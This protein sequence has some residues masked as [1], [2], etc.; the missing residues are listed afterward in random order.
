MLKFQAGELATRSKLAAAIVLC[1]VG[2]VSRPALAQNCTVRCGSRQIQFIPGQRVRLQM[3]NHTSSLVQIEQL[4]ETDPVP[5][6]PSQEL[7]VNSYFGTEPNT[8]VVFWDET[9]LPVKAVLFRPETNILRIEIFPG[10]RPPGDRSVYIEND[11]H[12]KLF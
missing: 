11:G 6:L 1:S 4:S 5:L 2:I 10:G 12:V 9:S 3:V 8:S 7:E